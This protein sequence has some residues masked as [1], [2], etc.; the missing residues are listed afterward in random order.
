MRLRDRRVQ[1]T[2]PVRLTCQVIGSPDPRI[3]W[4]KD[5]GEVTPD[6]K[7]KLRTNAVAKFNVL[8]LMFTHY[9]ELVILADLH[10]QTLIHIGPQA[11]S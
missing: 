5:G 4:F 3:T 7:W 6:S 10:I 11:L 1:A 9:S 2:Y 8:M